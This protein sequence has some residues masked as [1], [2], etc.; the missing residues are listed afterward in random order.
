MEAPRIKCVNCIVAIVRLELA[1]VEIMFCLEPKILREIL[2]KQF[3]QITILKVLVNLMY[4][5]LLTMGF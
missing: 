5:L 2:C 4:T 1:R 3:Q